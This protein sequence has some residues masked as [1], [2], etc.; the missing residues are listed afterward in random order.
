VET[1][2]G[3]GHAGEGADG[4]HLV[5][6]VDAAGAAD[7]AG[8]LLGGLEALVGAEPA[9]LGD[10]LL[11]ALYHFTWDEFCDWYLELAKV[12]L[13]EGGARAEAT[14]AVLGHVLE[15]V[16]RLLHPLTPFITETLWTTL[17]GRESVVVAEWPAP[18]GVERDEV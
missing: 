11:Q 1:V 14:Q 5:G 7:L 12:Q 6:E 3:F 13:A 10:E 4:R 16:L 2:L 17:T 9:D 15:V 8:D 18:S